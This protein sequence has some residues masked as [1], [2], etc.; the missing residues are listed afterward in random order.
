MPL[1]S[2]SPRTSRLATVF[3]FLPALARRHLA[4]RVGPRGGVHVFESAV[5]VFTLV[6]QR[7][8][9]CG[10]D[11]VESRI[12]Q[13]RAVCADGDGYQLFWKKGNGRW[14]VYSAPGCEPFVGSID[15][16]LAE[17]SRDPFGCYWS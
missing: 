9:G 16:C 6:H 3:D 12:A 1:T 17:I 14:T 11:L 8:E 15:E 5:G 10:S 4:S 2:A 7:R 13:L